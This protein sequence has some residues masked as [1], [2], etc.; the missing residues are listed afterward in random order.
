MSTTRFRREA[1]LARRGGTVGLV[2]WVEDRT[3]KLSCLPPIDEPW[4]LPQNGGSHITHRE[5]GD[6]FTLKV[7]LGRS[8]DKSS[9]HQHAWIKTDQQ[10]FLRDHTRAPI[11]QRVCCIKSLVFWM[12]PPTESVE[13]V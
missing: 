10:C 3:M 13:G 1:A 12:L 2:E 4:T 11:Q 8:Q 7:L 9:W 5:Y 6:G